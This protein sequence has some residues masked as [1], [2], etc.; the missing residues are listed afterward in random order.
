MKL[1]SIEE[2]KECPN[3]TMQLGQVGVGTNPS[4]PFFNHLILKTHLG[5]VNLIDP[6]NTWS[7]SYYDNKVP[8]GLDIRILRKGTLITFELED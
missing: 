4:S 1:K 3:V 2:G 5:F 7:C 8:A 6:H